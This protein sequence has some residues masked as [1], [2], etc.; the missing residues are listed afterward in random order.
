MQDLGTLGPGQQ[1]EAHAINDSTQVAGLSCLDPG[2]QVCRAFLWTQSAGMKDLGSLGGNFSEANGINSAGD[3]VGFSTV[4]DGTRHAFLWTPSG[5]M[6]QLVPG[7]TTETFAWAINDSDEVAGSFV[8]P[9]D[10]L[11][12]GFVW[13][14]ST[15]LRD[16]G[17]LATGW[18]EALAIN[19]SGDLVGFARDAD[20]TGHAV[21]WKNGGAIQTIGPLVNPKVPTLIAGVATGINAAGQIS[22]TGNSSLYLLTPR[23]QTTLTSSPN[24]SSDGQAVTFKADVTTYLGNPPDGDSVSFMHGK[25]VLGAGSLNHGIASFTTSSLPVGT[26]GVQA[27]HGGD[28]NILGSTS[29]TVGQVVV[30]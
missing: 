5:G 14:Q 2:N 30:K 11:Y 18:S 19:D 9:Q 22:A 10:H 21:I 3:V 17:T 1:N 25:T 27:V 12:H 13:S 7:E 28:A 6:R 4:A 15:G 16:L 20:G 29:A 26:T 8:H 24:P 23:T